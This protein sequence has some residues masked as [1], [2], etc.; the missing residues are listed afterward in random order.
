MQCGNCRFENMPGTLACGRCGTSLRLATAVL[1]VHPPRARPW[2]KRIRRWL[3][4]GRP[5][6]ELRDAVSRG[7]V[8][9]HEVAD[10]YR[11]P[12]PPT[13]VC[14]RMLVPGWPQLYCGQK[15]RARLFF[16]S[17]ITL[18]TLAAGFWGSIRGSVLAGLAFSV[19]ASSVID[20]ML[21]YGRAFP[22]RVATALAAMALLA[23]GIYWP[24]GWLVTRVADP[25]R[26]EVLG[27]PFARGDIV[28]ANQWAYRSAPPRVGDVV[29]YRID[30]VTP[31]AGLR[32]R[33]LHYVGEGIDRILAG[34]GDTLRAEGGKYLVN[35]KDSP[36][37]PLNPG[38]VHGVREVRVPADHYL[39]FPTTAPGATVWPGPD[40]NALGIVPAR[41]IHAR[42][43]LR[44]QPLGRFWWIR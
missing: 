42:A 17:Y 39:I 13:G 15:L 6:A 19:H 2:Q 25:R 40:W 23:V 28:L 30:R 29:V 36:W 41:D 11:F 26:I 44:N 4:L 12:V 33:V 24:A 35:G 21:Q 38:L 7:R 18:L 32:A 37:L 10:F 14:A 22:S 34:P 16:W 27:E 9:A 1:D 8:F 5:R 20:I 43:Y 3:P 31:D